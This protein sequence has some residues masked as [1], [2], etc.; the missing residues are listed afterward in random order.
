MYIKI[1][2]WDTEAI[3]IKGKYNSIKDCIEKNKHLSFYRADLQK[4]DLRN[5]DLWRADLQEADFQKADLQEADLQG[6]N[7]WGADL[8][9]ANLQKVK[10]YSVDLRE[11]NLRRIKGINKYAI[12]PLYGILDNKVN[13]AYKLVDKDNERIYYSGLKYKIGKTIKVNKADTDEFNNCGTGINLATLDWCVKHWECDYKIL[14]CKFKKEDI[15][16]IPITSDGTFRVYKC[17]VIGEKNLKEL[18]LE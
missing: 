4:A 18:G 6:T 7:L 3:I 1:K 11:A 14:I 2:R 17:K 10:L 5:A 12:N 15:A 8:R 9:G 13:I 16:C